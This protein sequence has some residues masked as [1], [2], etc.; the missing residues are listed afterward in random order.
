MA[1][2]KHA[3]LNALANQLETALGYNLVA[4]CLYGPG[5]RDDSAER[6]RQL[7]TLLIV[8]DVSPEALR[9]VEA[10]VNRWTKKGHPPPLIFAEDGWRSSTD[11]FPI[12]IEDMREAHLLLKGEPPFE[13]V[14]TTQ[15]DLRR[16]LEREVRGKLLQLRTEYVAAAPDGKA[17]GNL[18]IDSATTFFVLFRA[19]LRLV[20]KKP[21]Q[22]R[23]ALVRDAAEATGMD[24]DAFEWILHK[25][26]G[27]KAPALSAYD[28]IGDR[29]VSQIERLARFVDSYEPGGEEAEGAEGAEEAEEAGGAEGAGADG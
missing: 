11:V 26:A 14:T 4:F 15:E 17:V 27:R 8:N 24:Y 2:D 7:T 22:E 10:A 23:E 1:K 18:L 5:V 9:P 25:L 20:G 28:P 6:D 3:Q 29:Y 21:P 13:G 19:V 12:E 16:E